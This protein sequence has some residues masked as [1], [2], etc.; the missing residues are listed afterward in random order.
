MQN[1]FLAAVN[2]VADLSGSKYNI[3]ERST[4]HAPVGGF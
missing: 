1:E 2:H 3:S 4:G